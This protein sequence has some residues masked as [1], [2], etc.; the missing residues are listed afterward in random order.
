MT[1][2]AAATETQMHDDWPARLSPAEDGL[3]RSESGSSRGTERP[4][5]ISR[6]RAYQSDYP[7]TAEVVRRIFREELERR[8]GTVYRRL[9]KTPNESN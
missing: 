8:F 4:A 1:K 2:N 7:L 9:R 6:V 5:A 3:Q